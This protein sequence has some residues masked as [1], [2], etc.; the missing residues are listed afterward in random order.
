M[1]YGKLTRCGTGRS[2]PFAPVDNSPEQFSLLI[3][4][5]DISGTGCSVAC[6]QRLWN[7]TAET[8]ARGISTISSAV[9]G[10]AVPAIASRPPVEP[11]SRHVLGPAEIGLRRG[12]AEGWLRIVDP[13]QG[14]V[15]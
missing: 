8:V 1:R 15:G 2:P 12:R 5:I 10:H 6:K 11:L 9:P 13:A 4:C 7:F 3:G 14:R